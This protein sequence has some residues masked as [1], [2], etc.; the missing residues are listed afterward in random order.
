M[1]TEKLTALVETLALD[2]DGALAG[3]VAFDDCVL[4]SIAVLQDLAEDRGAC[5]VHRRARGA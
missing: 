5:V 4:A 1:T 3:G 2:I